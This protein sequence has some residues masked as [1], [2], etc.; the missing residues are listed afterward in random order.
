MSSVD[1]ISSMFNSESEKLTNLINSASK[2]DSLIHEIVETY[3]QIMNVS[4]MITMLKQ[5]LNE[6]EHKILLEKISKTEKMISEKF[7]S[8]IH[9]QIMDNLTKSI[10]E[11][12][13]NLQSNYS[14]EKSKKEIETEAKLY[15]EL[16]QTLSTKE[17]VQ[18]Y[19]QGLS[20]D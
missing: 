1:D 17:F 13:Q 18:Q 16:R 3:Y 5:Q 12:T 9:P 11:T 4:S 10:Q 14:A 6:N 2:P 7:N 19:D 8:H 20:N 15:E